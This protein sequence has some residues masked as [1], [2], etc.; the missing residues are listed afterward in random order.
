MSNPKTYANRLRRN[1]ADAAS[2]PHTMVCLQP[3]EAK[4]IADLLYPENGDSPVTRHEITKLREFIHAQGQ[5]LMNIAILQKLIRV[6]VLGLV[7]FEESRDVMGYCKAWIDDGRNL[8]HKWP[9]QWP[10]VCRWLLDIGFIPVGGTIGLPLE[11]IGDRAA[12]AEERR[13]N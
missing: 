5:Q 8:P 1:A 7:E 10:G 13:V 3:D 9:D 4:G 2:R 12:A 11:Q 6:Y